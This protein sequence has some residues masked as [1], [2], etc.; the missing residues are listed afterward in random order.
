MRS[1]NRHRITKRRQWREF[2]ASRDH[3]TDS[4]KLWRTIKGIDG[5]SNHTSENED[6][7]F[8]EIP[9]TSPKMIANSFNHQ[10]TTSKLIKHSSSRTRQVSKDVK[11]MTLEGAESFTS[12]LR[13]C[14]SSRA[15]GPDSLNI[16]QLKNLGP[17]D[18]EHLTPLYNASLKSCCLPSIWNTSLVIPIPKTGKDSSQGTSYRAISLLC[19]SAKVL[20]ALILPYT[21]EFIYQLKI[22]TASDPNTRLHLPSS[23]SYHTSR[24][25]LTSG[26]HLTV[27]CAWP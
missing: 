21:N 24:Q 13:I 6:I 7:T 23:S 18:T 20:E 10:F 9:Q 5:K 8:T 27:Q 12:A 1:P 2:V 26:N 4:T 25:A 11:R 14:R 19:P 15:Y 22:N 17:L 3:R 16:F